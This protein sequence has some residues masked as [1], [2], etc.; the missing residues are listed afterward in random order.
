[1]TRFPSNTPASPK[2]WNCFAVIRHGTGSGTDGAGILGRRGAAITNPDMVG[3]SRGIAKV[4]Q[5]G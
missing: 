3:T 1:M 4:A 2:W 5:D